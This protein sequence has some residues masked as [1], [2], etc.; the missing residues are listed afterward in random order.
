[1]G[2]GIL[3]I[4]LRRLCSLR[5]HHAVNGMLHD[6]ES[7]DANGPSVSVHAVGLCPNHISCLGTQGTLLARSLT[8]FVMPGK[9]IAQPL[10]SALSAVLGEGEGCSH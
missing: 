10:G 7:G 1:M 8:L 2:G 3:D 5:E 6:P 9:S 4:L